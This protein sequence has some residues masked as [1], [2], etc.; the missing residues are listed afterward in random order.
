MKAEKNYFIVDRTTSDE[1]NLK[2]LMNIIFKNEIAVRIL[3]GE[4]QSY[5]HDFDINGIKFEFQDT[6]IRTNHYSRKNYPQLKISCEKTFNRNFRDRDNVILTT[7]GIKENSKID[8][9]KVKKRYERLLLVLKEDKDK[10]EKQIIKNK[11][12]S[13]KLV[14]VQIN[15]KIHIEQLNFCSY[16]ENDSK[17]N[18][19]DLQLSKLSEPELQ[20]IMYEYR[21]IKGEI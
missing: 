17:N 16:D 8:I 5:W 10:H 21:K 20:Q 14:Q 12:R 4:K 3:Q 15:A 19:F 1:D 9:D 13:D 11:V 7:I 2:K 6:P 18:R